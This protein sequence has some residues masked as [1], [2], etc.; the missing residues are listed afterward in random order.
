MCRLKMQRPCLL[1]SNR[2]FQKLKRNKIQKGVA[3]CCNTL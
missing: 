3:I 2:N 1:I